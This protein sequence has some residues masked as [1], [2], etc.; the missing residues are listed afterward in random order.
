MFLLCLFSEN[1]NITMKLFTKDGI[2][3]WG[4]K[5]IKIR[6]DKS[7]M[8]CSHQSMVIGWQNFMTVHK[9]LGI[10]TH[11]SF[12][13]KLSNFDS[14]HK[15]RCI[16][17]GQRGCCCQHLKRP[18]SLYNILTQQCST[19]T[20]LLET[21]KILK[22]LITQSNFRSTSVNISMLWIYKLYL[23]FWSSTGFKTIVLI[24]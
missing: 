13:W 24:R 5:K 23:Y 21:P 7:Q 9:D 16:V 3:L 22:M 17:Q 1:R 14:K 6:G 4:H 20:Y 12:I 10:Y 8:P 11:N 2:Y 19:L 18:C 15:S